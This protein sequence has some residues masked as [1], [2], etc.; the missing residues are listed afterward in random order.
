MSK[1]QFLK[2]KKK[3]NSR[4]SHERTY[5]WLNKNTFLA[6][7]QGQKTAYT[8]RDT[9]RTDLKKEIYQLQENDKKFASR[10]K[11]RNL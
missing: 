2:E 9:E 11:R 5:I 4:K 6:F 7:T 1:L 3:L 8:A 10:S